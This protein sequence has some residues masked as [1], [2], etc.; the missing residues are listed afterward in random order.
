MGN[1]KYGKLTDFVLSIVNKLEN[2][3]EQVKKIIKLAI[4]KDEMLMDIW[5]V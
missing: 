4:A 1:I 5:K 2:N 3:E